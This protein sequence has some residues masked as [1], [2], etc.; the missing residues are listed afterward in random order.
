MFKAIARFIKALNGN[1]KKSQ[2]AAGFAWGLFLGLIPAGNIFWIAIFIL[3]FLFKNNHWSKM[4][5]MFV[6]MAFSGL[7]RPPLDLL[8]WW[9]LHIDSLQ[10]FFTNLY[11]MPFVPFTKFYNTLVAGGLAGGVVLCIPVYFLFFGLVALYRNTIGE[12]LRN[13]KVIKS[14]A[15]KLPFFP[16][17]EKIFSGV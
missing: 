1:V 6:L 16:I 10:P 5:F 9:L 7:I 2:I 3:S 14:I 12:K 15:G 4:L 8:G 17:I 13:S 11:N